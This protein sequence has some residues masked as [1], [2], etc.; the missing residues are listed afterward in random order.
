MCVGGNPSGSKTARGKRFVG[1]RGFPRYVTGR[2]FRRTDKAVKQRTCVSR[3]TSPNA[4]GGT[5]RR[6]ESSVGN[7]RGKAAPSIARAASPS[8]TRKLSPRAPVA[9]PAWSRAR[10]TGV[11]SAG[12]AGPQSASR[13]SGTRRGVRR[14]RETV[15][16]ETRPFL[17][18]RRPNGTNGLCSR[19]PRR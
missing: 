11:P 18:R 2:T 1:P 17:R 13:P 7:G 19:L 10:G 12:R 8:E 9:T 14:S 4:R 16:R 15:R 6:A 3:P 5:R